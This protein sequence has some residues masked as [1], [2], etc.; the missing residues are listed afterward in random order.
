MIAKG[1]HTEGML[2][3]NCYKKV[4]AAA[5]NYHWRYSLYKAEQALFSFVIT[6][7][8]WVTAV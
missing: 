8:E 2:M 4:T 1:V 7:P 3:P 6:A 5:A